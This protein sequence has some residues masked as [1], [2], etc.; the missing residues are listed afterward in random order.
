M[1]FNTKKFNEDSR[2]KIPA[3]LHL[4]RLGYKYLSLKEQSWDLDTNIFPDIFKTAISKINPGIEAAEAGRLLEDVKLL[5][6]N[7]D[8]GKAFFERLSERSNTKLIDFEKFNNNTFH[9]VTELTCQNGD[10]EFRPDITLLINGMPL[11]FIEV[12]KPNNREGIL[13][14]RDRVNKRFQN[15]KFKRFANITQFMIFSNNMEYDD[16][17]PEPVQGA[18]YAS[19][20][21]HK[22]VFNY[23]REEEIL[24]LTAL[25][26]PVSDDDELKVLKDNNLEVIRSN[27]EFQTNKQPER[28]TNRICTSLLSRDR[29]AFILRYA[30]A[31]VSESDG[32][33]KHIMRYP[34]LFATKAIERKLSEGV[35]KG[36]IWHTQGSGKTA[37]TFYNVRFLTDYFQ[38]QQVIPK[39]YFIVDRLDLLQQAQREF[40]ARG[41]TVHTINSRDAFTRDIKATQVIHNHSGKPEIT[42]VNIQK[43]KDDPDVVSTKD[44]NVAIQRVYFLDEVHRSYNPKGSFLANLSQS[45]SNAI[46]IGLTGTPL[47]GDDY[48]SR[49]LFGDY[50]HKYYYNASIAD[51]YTLRLIRE[52]ISTQYKIEL[53]K[54]LEEAEV[55]MGDVDRKLIYA[56]PSFVEPMLTYIVNDFEKSRGALN[57]TTIGG[58]VI[59]DSSDQAKQMFEI[60]NGVYAETPILP[61]TSNSKTEVLEVAEPAPTSY[62]ESAKQAQKVKNAALILHDIGT[63]EE[64]KNWVEDFKAGKIDF[65][66]VYNML[67]T[68]FDAKRL[69]K[70][71][72]GRVIRK[73]NLLQALTRVNRTYKDFRYGYVVDFADIRKEF[74]ATNK[75]YFDELQSELGDEMEHYSHLFKSQE[76]I[77]QEIEHI[78]DVLFRFDTD[79]MEEFCNQISQIQDRDTVLALKKAL[80]DARSLYNLIRLQGEY[81]FLDELDFAKLNVLYRETS[82][83]LDLLNLKN[84]LENGEDTSNLLNRALEDVIF[85]FVKIGEEE[86]VLADK[87]KNT[88]RQTREAL[89]S[90]FDQQ[91]PQFISLKEELERLFKKK[92]LSEVTQDEMVANIDTLNK[93]HDRVKELNRQNN[94]LR[95]KY[96]GDAKYTRIHKRLQER[97][98]SQSDISE[99]E[100][101]IFEALA[102]VK[103]DAD[104]Q[105][106]NNSQVLDNESYFERQMMPL[107]IGRFMKE[108]QIK[109]NADASRYI[110]HLVV[111]EYLKEFNTGSQAW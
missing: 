91:D 46:K 89:A 93:I 74:D 88:L 50:I 97:Q 40:T 57:D 56:H 17:D 21:Y 83:H 4:M 15:P 35:K 41:L 109:L 3:I 71:Y 67:L 36:I 94:Q 14:E 81:D 19:S 30:L 48:N 2:V 12:K 20:S 63:K 85:K 95:Q 107:V 102:G 13:A 111:A 70:L 44:Y 51:G 92:N 103:Q 61:Q 68:G 76:E 25:L 58:M 8:L 80:A 26:K 6:D 86:L 101:K 69:K 55:K 33:Q 31:Y 7:E 22:P 60:F 110:N 11:V 39:F 82:N 16:G 75:A 38:K 78:K 47:L 77:K 66:F 10:E 52:E 43:F 54:A 1:A 96:L 18:F 100:R 32:L 5:L 108:Q 79:N 72:L 87:L 62:A 9:V 34:Q 105:V 49:A 59:C 23:F 64:R 65:L 53:Q 27:P 28:P 84:D 29:L 98:Q 106:L 104:E 45:D 24:N 73:H 99:S 42:V 37:L 90:N